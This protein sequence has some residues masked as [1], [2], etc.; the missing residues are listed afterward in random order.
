MKASMSGKVGVG[1][2][3][4]SPGVDATVIYNTCFVE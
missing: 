1:N 4:L 2:P 3:R